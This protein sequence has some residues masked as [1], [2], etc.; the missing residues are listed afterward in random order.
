MYIRP[1]RYLIHN[2]TNSWAA[3]L[4]NYALYWLLGERSKHVAVTYFSTIDVGIII[5]RIIKILRK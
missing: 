3:Q 2:I 5:G 1:N 4:T